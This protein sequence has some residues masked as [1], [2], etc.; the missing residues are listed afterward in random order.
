MSDPLALL[1]VLF[2]GLSVVFLLSGVV[3]LRR[4]RPL[5]LA[6]RLTFA[7]L[8]LALAGFAGTVTVATRGYR[9]FTHEEVAAVVR[10]E[11]VGPRRFRAHF[12][13]AD[14]REAS[15]A[16]AGDELYVDAHILKWRPIANFIGLHTA[17]ELDR[18]SGRYATLAEEREGERTVQ[19]L[20]QE[21]PFDMFTLR[22]RYALLAPLLDAEYGSA[23]FILA[24]E[25]AE[26]EL[27]V[28]TT[29][30]LIRRRPVQ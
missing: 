23:S 30:L 10:T 27:R 22:R 28:S 19:A 13:F 12:R 3:A 6:T 14:G 25:A 8:L 4:G 11:P 16:L 24:D 15:F 5:R 2:A 20:S 18:V 1:A 21:K 7:V 29:G 17:Y 26:F 9:A